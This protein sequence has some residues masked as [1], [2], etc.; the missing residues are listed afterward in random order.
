MFDNT[1][2]T[3]APA[4]LFTKTEPEWPEV[5]FKQGVHRVF[6]EKE[7]IAPFQ[8]ATPVGEESYYVK[9]VDVTNG[10][11]VMTMF[12]RGGQTWETKVPLGSFKVKYATGMKWYGP[13]PERLFGPQTRVNE[14]DSVFHFRVEGNRVNGYTIQ[15]I[16]QV[17]GNL[18]TRPIGR[19]DF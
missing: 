18:K 14:A 7:R 12:V 2:Q 11:T 9:L 15:L 8:I 17:G 13:Q 3:S 1:P 6:T 16:K 5:P 4:P 10:K 19:N